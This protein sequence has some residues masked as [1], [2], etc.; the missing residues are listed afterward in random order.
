MP[1]AD[2]SSQTRAVLSR[3]QS[4]VLSLGSYFILHLFI[5]LAWQPLG[6]VNEVKA[7]GLFSA[8]Q[9]SLTARNTRYLI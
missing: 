6:R 8:C 3:V 7:V 4:M 5:D 1:L 2:A 9:C